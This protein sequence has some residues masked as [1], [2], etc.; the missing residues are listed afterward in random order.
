MRIMLMSVIKS[1]PLKSAA[2]SQITRNQLISL[3]AAELSWRKCEL[4]RNFTHTT[5]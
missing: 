3:A 4:I 2:T 1:V 5:L